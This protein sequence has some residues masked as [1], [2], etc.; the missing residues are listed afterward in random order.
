MQTPTIAIIWWTGNFWIFW[1]NYFESKWLNVI[2]SSR[3]TELKPIEAVK[4]ADI[5]I[6][7]VSIRHTKKVIQELLPHIPDNRL[8]LDFTGIKQIATD[9]MIKYTRWEVVGTHPMFGPKVSNLAKQNIA[10]DPINPGEKWDFIY[11]LWKEDW[12]NLIN[13]S[14]QKHDELI[15]LVQPMTHFIN[16]VFGHIL[17]K[18]SIHPE[19]LFKISTPISRMQ[20]YIFSRFLSQSAW[21]YADMQICNE[22]YKKE[23]LEEL[24]EFTK[25]LEKIIKNDNFE[26]F[27]NEFNDL[28]Y[29][30]W[31]DFLEKALSKSSEVDEI[32]KE[33]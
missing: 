20:A 16:F 19:E 17:K 14:S 9:E 10:Y 25:Y 6:I 31:D 29:F 13:M 23:I 22:I 28:K 12:A 26:A 18:R 21:L 33:E 15:A 11:S 2:I 7:S 27:E 5:I 4:I 30:I 24:L 32:L 1:K 3:R 8:I